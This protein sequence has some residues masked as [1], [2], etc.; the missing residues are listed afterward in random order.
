[1]H[2]AS[3]RAPDKAPLNWRP[4]K[5]RSR[6]DGFELEV[7]PAKN[8]AE[9]GIAAGVPHGFQGCHLIKLD[10]YVFE[11]H[12]TSEII[13]KFLTERPLDL[14]GLSLPGMPTGVPG[15]EDHV[16]GG[17]DGHKRCSTVAGS[18]VRP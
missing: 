10:G 8:L 2:P 5:P 12:I 9:M 7:K 15:M 18:A 11:G 6:D 16:A 17:P 3:S 1:M 4:D 14:V 13:K